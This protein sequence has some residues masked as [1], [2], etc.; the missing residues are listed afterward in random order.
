[1]RP[2]QHARSSAGKHRDWHADLSI[3][4]FM[5]STKMACPDLRH[6]VVLHNADLGTELA[7]RA[8]P[9]RPDARAVALRHVDE[10]L[11]CTPTL[12]EWLDGCNLARL[13]RPLYRRLPLRFDGLAGQVARAQGLRDDDWPQGVLDLLLLPMRLAGPDALGLL[14]NGAAPAIVRQIVGAPRAV[15]GPGGGHAIFDPAHAAEAV[16]YWLFGTIPPLS[17]VAAAVQ[18]VPGPHLRST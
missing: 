8:F 3:H 1:M 14:L 13:P 4:E 7:A 2:W 9:G 16:I 12:A 15:P 5:D 11:G 10:D 17:D 18:H 6:R